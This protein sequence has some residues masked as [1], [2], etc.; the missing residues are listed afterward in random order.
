MRSFFR[1]IRA[2]FVVALA[3]LL[4]GAAACLVH[5]PVFAGGKNYELYLA[6]SSSSL[7]VQTQNPVLDKWL[8]APEG[9]SVRYDG[10]ESE[11][12][13][14]RFRAVVLF[15][16]ETADVVNYYCYSPCLGSCVSL[17]GYRVNLH[18]AVGREQTAAGTPL[19]FGGF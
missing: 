15:R 19:I 8:Y 16:E 2:M 11:A 1:G 18:I 7:T 6:P 3:F 14:G 17:G 13:L 9:E 5:A 12:L 10:D 4:G